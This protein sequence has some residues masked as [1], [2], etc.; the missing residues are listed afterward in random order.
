MMG[1]IKLTIIFLSIFKWSIYCI[2]TEHNIFV[3]LLFSFFFPNHKIFKILNDVSV[4]FNS[5]VLLYRESMYFNT[6]HITY[7]SCFLSK[8]CAKVKDFFVIVVVW[9][10]LLQVLNSF[11]FQFIF[12]SVFF[13]LHLRCINL[14]K[15]WKRNTHTNIEMVAFSFYLIKFLNNFFVSWLSWKR[16]CFVVVCLNSVCFSVCM[17]VCVYLFFL[18]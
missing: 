8:P 4:W 10:F 12:F 16:V 3:T 7:F 14:R 11:F 13:L 18:Y 9:I 5:F 1:A 15:S 6:K 2:V 17:C